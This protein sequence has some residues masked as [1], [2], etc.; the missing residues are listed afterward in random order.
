MS[1]IFWKLLFHLIIW[2]I[3]KKDLSILRGVRFL[4]TQWDS[5]VNSIVHCVLTDTTISVTG[6]IYWD[7]ILMQHWYWDRKTKIQKDNKTKH[8]EKDSEDIQT[9]SHDLL[10]SKREGWGGGWS[11]R[12]FDLFN[13]MIYDLKRSLV[14]ILLHDSVLHSSLDDPVKFK[15]FS[16]FCQKFRVLHLFLGQNWK[17]GILLV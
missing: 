17:I 15:T 14:L 1:Y 3:K 12:F 9:T 5:Y 4:L 13:S 6:A 10:R 7:F 16:F 11:S 2:A 8:D